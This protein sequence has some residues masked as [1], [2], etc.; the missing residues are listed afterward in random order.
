M[1]MRYVSRLVQ[2][3]RTLIGCQASILDALKPVKDAQYDKHPP[4]LRRNCTE[5]TREQ[6]LD[7]LMKWACDHQAPNIYWLCGMAGTGKTTIARTFCERLKHEHLL[8]ASFF[9][10]RTIEETREIRAVFPTIAHELA[11][12]SVVIPSLLIEA[13][14]RDQG[15]AS[16][17]P[18]VQFTCLI[19]DPANQEL[20][21]LHI[22]AVDA[23]DEFKTI[24]DARLLLRT[25]TKSVP[26][27]SKI[28][29]FVTSRLVPQLEEVFRG[30]NSTSFH[31]HN[32]EE[33]LVRNDIEQ[34]LEE[35]WAFIR[36]AKGVF[37]SWPTKEDHQAVLN[38]AG[39]LFIYAS[40]I[41]RFL[42][43][44]KT[45]NDCKRRLQ[46]ILSTH[47]QWDEKSQAAVYHPLDILYR[48][49]LD[50]IEDYSRLDVLQVLHVVVTALHPL[51]IH[52]IAHLLG[53]YPPSIY[54]ALT[55]LRA[56]I[57]AP[58]DETLTDPV[59][60]FHA[61]FP[62]FLHTP[63]RSGTHHIPE[64]Q[65]HQDMLGLC[66]D[67]FQLM[68][69]ENICKLSSNDVSLQDIDLSPSLNIPEALQYSCTSWI[70]HLGCVLEAQKLSSLDESQVLHFFDK[71][72]LHWIECMALL[73][74]LEDAMYALYRI[75]LSPNVRHV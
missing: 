9:C 33:S 56:V 35:Q 18:N 48:Q 17:Q 43:N 72:V 67:I 54:A 47:T 3:R 15:I 46:L 21:K 57:M 1:L 16:S 45:A 30:V 62:D 13:V 52:A 44:S 24:D 11:S 22:V 42:E 73:G 28:K 2:M 59:F 61:S 71:H 39:K 19:R 32:V 23:F 66:L 41:C 7:N 51:S 26:D 69:K 49:V 65:A 10:S 75:E 74:K 55:E 29:F 60:P 68:L 4:S 36:E 64:T 27:L 63:S 58:D 34:Y 53:T 6:I 31:L 70:V 38:S 50:A 20:D 14:R 37:E 25:F 40:T 8:G 12:R 5:G